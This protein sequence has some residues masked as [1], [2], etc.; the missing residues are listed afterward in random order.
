MDHKY[1]RE[2]NNSFANRAVYERILMS[3]YV[4]LYCLLILHNDIGTKFL[5]LEENLLH[6]VI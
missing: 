3:S 5:H 4:D 1:T 2:R 6:S